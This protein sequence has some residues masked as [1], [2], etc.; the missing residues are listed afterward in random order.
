M[1]SI[2]MTHSSGSMVEDLAHVIKFNVSILDNVKGSSLANMTSLH[3]MRIDVSF[4]RGDNPVTT[5]ASA[6]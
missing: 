6:F 1:I 4:S 5:T 3:V 2:H